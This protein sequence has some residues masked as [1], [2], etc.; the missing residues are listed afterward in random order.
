M[1]LNTIV[2]NARQAKALG[3]PKL[4]PYPPAT[5]ENFAFEA[6]WEEYVKVA[7]APDEQEFGV[8]WDGD[9]FRSVVPRDLADRGE[10]YCH[11]DFGDALAYLRELIAA[12]SAQRKFG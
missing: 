8:E 5:D 9:E 10:G 11:F 12:S 6:G 1:A 7:D 3:V 4:N 2:D